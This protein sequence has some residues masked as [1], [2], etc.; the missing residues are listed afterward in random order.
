[1]TD[2]D[3]DGLG[4]QSG[5]RV[6]D[7]ILKINHDD[8]AK[9]H[10][11]QLW[12]EAEGA[13]TLEIRR[14]D[15]TNDQMIEMPELPFLQSTLSD[16]P[17][18]ILGFVF[19]LSGFTTWFRRP[20]LVQA[21]AL[22]WLNWVI[23]MAFVLAPASSRDLLLARELESAFF[24]AM[25][26]VLINFIS[27]FHY[28]NIKKR[29]NQLGILMLI[30]MSIIILIG[31]LLQSADIIHL[32]SLLRKLLLVTFSIGVLFT[33]WNLGALLKLPKDKPEKNQANILLMGM[34]IG[35]LPF[36]LLTAFPVIV[37]F[38][39]IMNS[40][41]SSLF[42]SVIPATWYYAIVN[43]YLPDSRKLIGTIISYFIAGVITSFVVCYLL[44]TIKLSSSFN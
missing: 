26:I 5:V 8:P 2:S 19:W 14:L 11:V 23:G 10:I 7:L 3:P 4:Y 13:S 21:R 31:N 40:H 12:S 38:Q 41:V 24:S 16:I 33:L 35:F 44:L 36:V 30:S 34:V 25:P 28:N 6:G 20:F 42:V 15:Q 29:V 27:I 22:F 39:P 1:M 18:V 9:N 32:F 37:S 17:F 43:K